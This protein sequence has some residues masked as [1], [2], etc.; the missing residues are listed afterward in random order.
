M[1]YFI[2][3]TGQEIWYESPGHSSDS[4][5]KANAAFL[6][7]L[8]L[9]QRQFGGPKMQGAKDL[10]APSPNYEYDYEDHAGMD[11]YDSPVVP[12]SSLQDP[13][14]VSS[15]HKNVISPASL[16][17][18]DDD[19]DEPNSDKEVKELKAL[20]NKHRKE[21]DSL[22]TN[23]ND[24]NQ[25]VSYSP[26]EYEDP[27]YEDAWINWDSKRSTAPKK[28][29]PNSKKPTLLDSK[30]PLTKSVAK[31]VS[32]TT[33]K[34]A[35]VKTIHNGQKEVVLPRPAAPVKHPFQQ[36]PFENNNSP[37]PQSQIMEA[38]KQLS[39]QKPHSS[40]AIYDTIKQ[41]LRMEQS[42]DK[43]RFYLCILL[44][45]ITPK[46]IPSELRHLCFETITKKIRK[47]S[48]T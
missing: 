45:Y 8:M 7:N 24:W 43:V 10:D 11:W 47:S 35:A 48:G 30:K 2:T 20:V 31:I 12:S 18:S 37:S 3:V 19:M 46:F 17:N 15:Y 9:Y 16:Y 14:S 29:L 13:A 5:A 34:P 21:H 40:G 22:Y 41:I 33:Q 36:P 25:K 44:N 42:L 38:K 6:H 23:H 4:L 1:F 27:E 32:S 39:S 28:V 26:A